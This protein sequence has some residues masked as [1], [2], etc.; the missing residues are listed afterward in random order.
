MIGNK[1]KAWQIFLRLFCGDIALL[2]FQNAQCSHATKKAEAH[3]ESRSGQVQKLE[4]TPLKISC[5]QNSAFQLPVLCVLFDLV[6]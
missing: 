5:L 2:Y 3:L 1:E 6:F 4:K